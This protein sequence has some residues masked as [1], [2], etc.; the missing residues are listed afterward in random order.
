[1]AELRLFGASD[2]L[3]EI[4]GDISEEFPALFEDD[5]DGGYIAVSDGTLL[6]VR[7]DG[8]GIWRFGLLATGRANFHKDEG[9]DDD[10]H[11]DMVTLNLPPGEGEFR[12]V[13]L[14]EQKAV[15]KRKK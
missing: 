15:A 8:N 3:V 5:A 6:S 7:Y 4:E 9:A 12:W 11:S 14:G 2:D 13:V 10:R 1:M